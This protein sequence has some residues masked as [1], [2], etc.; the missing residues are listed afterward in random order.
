[1]EKKHILKSFTV[2]KKGKK[3]K[4]K[5]CIIEATYTFREENF[6]ERKFCEIKIPQNFLPLRYKVLKY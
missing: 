4:K 3:N 5:R 6:A 2:N 1:M